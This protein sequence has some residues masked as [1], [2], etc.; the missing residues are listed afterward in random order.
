M[1]I[2]DDDRWAVVKTFNNV[3]GNLALVN[4]YIC[5]RLAEILNLPMPAS[6]ICI[7]D[8]NTADTNG[9]INAN[10]LGY[11]FYST[12]LK[13]NTCLLYTSLGERGGAMAE[14]A[15][16]I[17][18]EVDGESVLLEELPEHERLRI[19]QRL[20]ECLMEPLGYREKP[21]L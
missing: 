16:E 4:E 13:K 3:Q 14:P 18:I 2:L 10:N 9:L 15:M 8:S 12:Y 7:C 19:S 21:A 5:Y 1:C 17:Y 6:G 11:G 20:Q